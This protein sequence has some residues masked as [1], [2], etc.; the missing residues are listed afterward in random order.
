MECPVCEGESTDRVC[1]CGFDSETRSVKGVIE[2]LN[3]EEALARSHELRD[4]VLSVLGAVA[5]LAVAFS[6]PITV[7]IVVGAVLVALSIASMVTGMRDKWDRAKRLTAA[8]EL[9]QLPE[10]RAIERD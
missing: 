10:A 8:R 4:K 7:T 9:K 5:F 1:A 3:E 6:A 2:K